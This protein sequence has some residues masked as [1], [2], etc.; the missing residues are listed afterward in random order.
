MINELL[1]QHLVSIFVVSNEELLEKLP[2]AL[3]IALWEG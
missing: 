1:L 2:R 3:A